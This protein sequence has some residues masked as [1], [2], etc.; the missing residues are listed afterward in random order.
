MTDRLNNIFRELS[1]CKVFA[2]IGCDHGYIAKEMIERKKCDLA[3]IADISAPC[4]KKA[5]ELLCEHIKSGKVKSIVS[6]GFDKIEGCDLALIAG[7]GGE[8]IISILTKSAFLPDKLVLQPMKNTDKVRVE[9]VKIGYKIEKDFTFKSGGKF[10]DIIVLSLGEDHLTEREIMF[11]RT[12][13][14]EL[15]V[16]FVEKMQ[17]EKK[18]AENFLK[19]TMPDKKKLELSAYLEM[20]N[21]YV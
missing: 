13:I 12:N 14:K 10:Y 2:D 17:L 11:G 19:M 21:D 3:I 20:V 8:E 7:M 9:V 4:L 5:E 15:P 6:D 18:K 1:N 16:A